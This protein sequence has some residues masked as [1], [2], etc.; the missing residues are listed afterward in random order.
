MPAIIALVRADNAVDPDRQG[1]RCRRRAAEAVGD[2][3]VSNADG[4][5]PPPPSADSGRLHHQATVLDE[6][7]VAKQAVAERRVTKASH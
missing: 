2:L 6:D 4:D 7:G 5:P 1:V 3:C